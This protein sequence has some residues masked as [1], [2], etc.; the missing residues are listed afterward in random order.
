M[1]KWM[2]SLLILFVTCLFLFVTK[3]PLQKG[4]SSFFSVTSVS[5]PFR[6]L[7]VPF[8]NLLGVPFR[9]HGVPFRNLYVPFRNLGVPFRDRGVPFRNL[10][11]CSF[12]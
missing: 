2:G 6:N 10:G 1:E 9:N 7:V 12:S 5:V 11:Q 3:L 4:P 8:R